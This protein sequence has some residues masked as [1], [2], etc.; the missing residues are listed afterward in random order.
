MHSRSC[1][2]A[3]SVERLRHDIV[4][5]QTQQRPG[6]AGA[7]GN[8]HVQRERSGH[9]VVTF[10]LVVERHGIGRDQHRA[11]AERSEGLE[12]R[13]VGPVVEGPR[14]G[15]DLTIGELGHRQSTDQRLTADESGGTCRHQAVE[16]DIGVGARGECSPVLRG[17]RREQ[18]PG[19]RFTQLRHA[20]EGVR[21]D[22]EGQGCGRR[23][24][25]QRSGRREA[26]AVLGGERRRAVDRER[27]CRLHRE[28]QAD[29]DR[30]RP[31][32]VR[33]GQSVQEH[34]LAPQLGALGRGHD[35]LD[36]VDARHRDQDAVGDRAARSDR[37]RQRRPGLGGPEQGERDGRP[38]RLQDRS[39]GSALSELDELL[40]QA[41]VVVVDERLVDGDG[42]LRAGRHG[43]ARG[44]PDLELAVGFDPGA[45]RGH[46]E[47]RR[48]HGLLGRRRPRG[49]CRCQRAR[50]EGADGTRERSDQGDHAGAPTIVAGARGAAGR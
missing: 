16:I 27:R 29:R 7:V 4:V 26:G 33:V 9:G 49:G 36:R 37:D 40:A 14:R 2:D 39:G 24:L 19:P 38:R 30:V 11:G 46:L 34:R 47:H 25:E 42:Q 31:L 22:G 43:V 28:H 3:G 50:G 15:V 5:G 44:E 1:G 21:S 45:D 23:I 41:L 17:H 35:E 18:R 48:G 6:R 12:R 10:Q 32:A 8:R 20:L 13:E